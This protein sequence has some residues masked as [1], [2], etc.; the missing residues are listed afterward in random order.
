MELD[1]IFISESWERENKTLEQ[2]IE[3][4]DY[5]IVSNVFQRKGIGGRPAIIA[6][7]K[8]FQVQNITNTLVQIPWGVEAVWRILTPPN[9][10]QNSKI[11]KIICCSFYSKPES[12]K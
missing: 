1:V 2:I 5:T 11:R 12:R 3:L 9:V 7:N 8:K 6:N 10:T 4:D